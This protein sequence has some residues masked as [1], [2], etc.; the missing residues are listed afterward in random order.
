VSQLAFGVATAGFQVEGGFNGPGQPRNNWYDREAAG[1]AEPSGAACE[2]WNRWEEDLDAVHAMGLDWYR[3]SVEWP[4]LQPSPRSDES[5]EPA[6]DDD[7]VDRYVAML[8]GAR[9]RSIEPVV[10]L[11]HFTHPRWLGLDLWQRPDSPRLFARYAEEAARRLAEG[12]IARG[13]APLTKYVTLNEPNVLAFQTWATGMF[14]GGG[15]GRLHAVRLALD[16]LLAAHVLTYAAIHRLHRE[17]GWPAPVVT[18]N[19]YTNSIYELDRGLVDRLLAPGRG[20]ARDDLPGYLAMRRNEWFAIRR[21]F[22]GPDRSPAQRIA[23]RVANWTIDTVGAGSLDVLYGETPDGALDVVSIDLYASWV[24]GY[25]R[26]PGHRTAGGRSMMPHR[27]LWEDP[28][29]PRSFAAFVRAATDHGLP[30][31]ILENGLCNRVRDGVG[32][33]RSDGWT[34]VRYLDAHVREVVALAES[35]VPVEA[36]VHW[37]LFDNYEW[38]SYE[39]RFGIH[40]IDRTGASPKR[41]VVDSMGDDSAGAY[42]RLV[43]ELRGG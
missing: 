40:G 25:L 3:L 41:L 8:A 17:R 15:P 21:R 16:H 5:S 9:E 38:G 20:I 30:V 31:W 43:A 29:R 2:C 26:V 37:S 33:P 22:G 32:Y 23:D 34:R 10:T 28:P 7:A 14:P 1:K 35:G 6:W 27:D 4:R 19:T 39:P 13:Q 18:T 42:A 12:L 24:S 36:Y 11:H